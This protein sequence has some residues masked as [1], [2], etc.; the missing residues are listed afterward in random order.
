MIG[1][2]SSGFAGSEKLASLREARHL[3]DSSQHHQVRLTRLT[4]LAQGV[5]IL[6]N[7]GYSNT[8]SEAR[9]T[10]R[11][12][13]RAERREEVI[14]DAVMDEQIVR[15]LAAFT[16]I[17]EENLRERLIKITEWSFRNQ[18]QARVI[19]SNLAKH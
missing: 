5:A 6:G 9:V 10:M 19:V 2:R 18:D 12:Q 7:A 14:G 11:N 8:A 17:Q 13:I 4:G 3:W 16:Q 1:K 15:F